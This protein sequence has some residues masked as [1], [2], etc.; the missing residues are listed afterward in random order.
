[1]SKS[2]QDRIALRF[3]TCNDGHYKR[4]YSRLTQIVEVWTKSL[5]LILVK[6]PVYNTNDSHHRIYSCETAELPHNFSKIDKFLEPPEIV[7]ILIKS[8]EYIIVWKERDRFIG[9]MKEKRK[10]MMETLLTVGV[11]A[12]IVTTASSQTAG[13]NRQSVNCPGREGEV[14]YI[15]AETL[16]EDIQAERDR[17]LAGGTPEPSYFFSLCPQNTFDGLPLVLGLDNML[18]GCGDL[19]SEDRVCTFLGGQS[20]IEVN[21]FADSEYPVQSV[22]LEGLT[23]T[24]YTGSAIVGPQSTGITTLNIRDATFGVSADSSEAQ[25]LL[26]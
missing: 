16:N 22:S 4:L 21:S 12:S 2:Q 20:Q 23:F 6:G 15:S 17:I 14:G 9:I 11:L 26:R 18:I 19:E 13:Y 10:T 7:L 24:G 5:F 3:C 25:F 1:M 8:L